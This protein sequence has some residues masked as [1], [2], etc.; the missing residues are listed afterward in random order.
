[1]LEVDC[2][3][4][5]E[6]EAEEAEVESVAVAVRAAEEVAFEAVGLMEAA[7]RRALLLQLL[8]LQEDS[9]YV[10][11]GVEQSCP[12]RRCCYC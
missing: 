3:T 12:L 6:P 8:H 5:V 7:R 9:N 11:V 1:M 10:L 4:W 2:H